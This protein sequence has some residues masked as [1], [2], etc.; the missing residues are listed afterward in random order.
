[1]KTYSKKGSCPFVVFTYMCMTRVQVPAPPGT[2]QQPPSQILEVGILFQCV[3]YLQEISKVKLRPNFLIYGH[4]KRVN[5]LTNPRVTQ[6][7]P[8]ARWRGVHFFVQKQFGILHYNLIKYFNLPKQP[9]LVTWLVQHTK[10]IF[11]KTYSTFLHLG[12]FV[13]WL[14]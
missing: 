9:I 14:R 5:R 1:M 3:H 6:I 8:W 7:L 13:H 11:Q 12:I 10:K 2:L 4:Q